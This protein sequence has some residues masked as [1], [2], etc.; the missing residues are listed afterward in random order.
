MT[1]KPARKPLFGG[2]L[3]FVLSDVWGISADD[4]A[5]GSVED[6][7][8]TMSIHE[9][10]SQADP[11]LSLLPERRRV[12]AERTL[13]AGDRCYMLVENEAAI[14]WWWVSDRSHTDHVAGMRVNLRP[15]EAYLYDIWTVEEHRGTHA[16][17]QLVTEV[18]ARLMATGNYDAF[19]TYIDNDNKPSQNFAKRFGFQPTQ[20][21]RSLRRDQRGWQIP[22]SDNPRGGPASRTRRGPLIP[23]SDR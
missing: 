14:A 23:E 3:E 16:G 10:T 18:F 13:R 20:Q 8:D 2:R 15:R 4:L 22:R 21:F 12:F 17:L 5:P 6:L 9:V 11:L 1:E 19:I 7:P